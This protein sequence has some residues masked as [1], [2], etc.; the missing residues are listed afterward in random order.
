MK[1][2][3]KINRLKRR[4]RKYRNINKKYRENPVEPWAF[5]RVKNEIKTV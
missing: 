1:I 4:L 2:W 5:I 3:K